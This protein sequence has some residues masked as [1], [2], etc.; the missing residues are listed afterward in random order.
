MA[1]STKIL[2]KTNFKDFEKYSSRFPL[3]Q[4]PSPYYVCEVLNE[5]FK[6]RSEDEIKLKDIT[7]DYFENYKYQKD[8]ILKGLTF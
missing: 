2:D 3:E 8:A 6:D 1:K 5:Y 7:D 4:K